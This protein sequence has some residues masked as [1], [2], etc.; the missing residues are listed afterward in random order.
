MKI[1]D[2]STLNLFD[3]ARMD[4]RP[5]IRVWVDPDEPTGDS[6]AGGGGAKLGIEQA[7]AELGLE[8]RAQEIIASNGG[9]GH[10]RAAADA[11]QRAAGL[12]DAV[13]ALRAGT[14][15]EQS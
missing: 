1:R 13:D 12:T 5:P 15:K 14:W 6:F 11:N 8:R 10:T 7:Y 3:D 2:R 9:V 4:S